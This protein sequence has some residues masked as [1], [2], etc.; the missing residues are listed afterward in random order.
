[1]NIRKDSSEIFYGAD[2]M[3]LGLSFEVNDRKFLR[4]EKK[5]HQFKGQN[6]EP[7]HLFE[8][9]LY[10]KFLKAKLF[11]NEFFLEKRRII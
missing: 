5:F 8:T 10:N 7:F 4:V 11:R 1:M 3:G 2:R 6:W 9:Y